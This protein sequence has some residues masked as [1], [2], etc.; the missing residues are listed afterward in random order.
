MRRGSEWAS[1]WWKALVHP[2][3]AGELVLGDDA[4]ARR[5]VPA[6][7]ASIFSL[8]AVYGVSMGLYR[9]L[10]PAMVSA[11][12][13]PFLY[14]L[15]LAV[16]FPAFYLLN[17]LAG[18]RMRAAQCLRLLLLAVSANALA[19]CSYAPVSY[20]FTLTTS[21]DGYAFLVL[22][23]V[24]VFAVAAAVSVAAAVLVFRATARQLGGGFGPLLVF[25]WALTYGAVGTQMSW[26]L[27]PWIATPHA[28]Y[29]PLRPIDGS[30]VQGLWALLRN[31]AGP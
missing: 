28:D 8:Y 14:L 5:L 19:L 7:L 9:G 30:F 25:G 27:R 26:V 10:L 23:H 6:L 11:L 16:C 4:R 22:M 1:L 17:C 24:A 31:V 3:A 13:L 20:F 15:T 18:P 12:K 2:G 29:A 21:Q